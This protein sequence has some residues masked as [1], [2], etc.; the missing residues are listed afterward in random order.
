MSKYG[1]L[2]KGFTELKKMVREL[3]GS[4]DYLDSAELAI[5]HMILRRQL[6][7][8][9]DQQQLADLSGVPFEDIGVIEMGLTHPNFG[10][11]VKP[12]TLTKLFQTLEIVGLKPIVAEE[13]ATYTAQ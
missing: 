2:N 8:G 9:Y 13:S 1:H 11:T 12:D 7:L 4:A 10:Y 5:G 6:E 3:P